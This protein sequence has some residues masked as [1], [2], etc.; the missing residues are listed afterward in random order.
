[1]AAMRTRMHDDEVFTDAG[2]VRRLLAGQLPRW[3]E[4]PIEPVRSCGTD[5]DIYR[6]GEDLVV[7]LPRIGWAADQ[8]LKEA[9]WLHRLAPHVPLTLPVPMA[10]GDPD[11]GYPFRW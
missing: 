2:L 8:A 5:H 10:L 4:L 1:M 11:E 9:A 6:L 3:A 7:R